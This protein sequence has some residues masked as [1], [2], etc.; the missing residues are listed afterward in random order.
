[1]D[2]S[3][4]PLSIEVGLLDGAKD[5]AKEVLGNSEKLLIQAKKK[6]NV[7]P[8]NLPK[9]VTRIGSPLEDVTQE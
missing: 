2:P 1:M 5:V 3:I 6:S 4:I 9:R 8:S 7:F